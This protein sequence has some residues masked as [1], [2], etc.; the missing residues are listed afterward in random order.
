MGA[1]QLYTFAAV[2]VREWVLPST[3]R[4]LKPVGGPPGREGL[5]VGCDDGMVCRIF[6]DN[7]F[8]VPLV[9][10]HAAVRC[11]DLSMERDKLAVV[12]EHSVVS[13]YELATASKL[14]E[15]QNAEA[16]AWN[17]ELPDMLCFSAHG[18]LSIKTGNFPL[19]QQKMEVSR[20]ESIP[21]TQPPY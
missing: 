20:R 19:H 13:V 2:R 18:T 4:Y 21:W 3:I 9:Q 11:L 8:H 7:P 12:D 15:E 5:I 16:V 1:R 10:H 6:I 17:T 14:F